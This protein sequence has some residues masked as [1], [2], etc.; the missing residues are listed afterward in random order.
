[1]PSSHSVGDEGKSGED[2][3]QDAELTLGGLPVRPDEPDYRGGNVVGWT[4]EK[5]AEACCAA[6]PFCCPQLSKRFVN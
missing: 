6:T 3:V 5:S 1:M 4:W 2:R